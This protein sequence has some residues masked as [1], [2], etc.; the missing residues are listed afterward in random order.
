VIYTA[1]QLADTRMR[2]VY[3]DMATISI[4]DATGVSKEYLVDGPFLAS[5]LTGQIVSP[6]TDVATPWTGRR[7]VGFN[8][9]ARQLDAVEQNQI[10]VKG[11]TVL[12]DRPPYIRVRHG[13]TTDMTNTLTKLPT[14]VLI[15]D[16]VQKRARGVL[17]QFIGIKFLPGVLSQIEGRLAMM[18]KSMVQ[19]QI[20]SAYTG[21]KANVSPDDPTVAEVEAYYSPVFPLL[22]LVLTF[23]LRSSL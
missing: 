3:P 13:L 1:G 10:A 19:A 23:H 5:A 14:I 21:I 18:L 4:Q 6:N 20:I 9:L 15:A 8:Q 11:V 16:E 12:E 17:E 22:Y 7:L 2:V